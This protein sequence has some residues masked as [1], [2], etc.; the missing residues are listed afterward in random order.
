MT[1]DAD[2]EL[3]RAVGDPVRVTTAD[4]PAWILRRY[5]DV[6][7]GFTST[8]LSTCPHL[9][10]GEDYRGYDLPPAFR[11]NIISSPPADHRR[12]RRLI[13]PLMDR[14][15][16]Q[17]I[18]PALQRT[19]REVF[20]QASTHGTFDL[21][22]DFAG[23]Y[24]AASTAAWL[25]LER[26]LRNT[27]L[28]WAAQLVGPQWATLR[29]RDTLPTMAA[30]VEEATTTPSKPG[31]V[32]DRLLAM[33]D[34]GQMRPAETTA[35]VF[36]LLFVWY[37]ISVNAVAGAV[38]VASE[39]DDHGSWSR[40]WRRHA[41]EALGRYTPQSIAFR[42]FAS[43]EQR[44]GSAV[45]EAGQT[46]L[47]SLAAA[48]KDLRDAASPRGL[49]VSFGYGPHRCP[50][51][52]IALAVIREALTVAQ[53]IAELDL[54]NVAWTPGLRAHGPRQIQA[55]IAE[56]DQDQVGRHRSDRSATAG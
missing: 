23:P 41:D 44:V 37:E 13:A 43:N 4:G 53:V 55:R 7:A 15:A 27:Y 18:R 10:T 32:I 36:Y 49:H 11:D 1:I 24:V 54:S 52:S 42:R 6:V 48:N 5:D 2:G 20:E 31:T 26:Q 29:G 39:S 30:L 47:L 45:I 25:G 28:A 3:A 33:R 17:A 9:A 35:M 50:G 16:A 51:Q 22:R 19:A 40:R 46:V 34:S 14:S 12:V 38:I 8:D 21:I 56:A